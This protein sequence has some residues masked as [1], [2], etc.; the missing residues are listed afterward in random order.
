MRSWELKLKELK[1]KYLYIEKPKVTAVSESRASAGN[2][3][4]QVASPS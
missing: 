3:P 1:K 4:V 2:G